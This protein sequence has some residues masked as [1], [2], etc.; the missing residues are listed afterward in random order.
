MQEQGEA[1]L[2]HVIEDEQLLPEALEALGVLVMTASFYHEYFK[3]LLKF[4]EEL[5][6][7][8]ASC[9]HDC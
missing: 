9:Y 5:S 1:A 2:G 8:T 3:Y 6:V 4:R 7:M